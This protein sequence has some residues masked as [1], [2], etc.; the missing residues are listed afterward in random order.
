[1][2]KCEGFKMFRGTM[3]VRSGN[4]TYLITGTWLFNPEYEC[5]Y[6]GGRSFPEDC[7][8]VYDDRTEE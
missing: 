6:C 1:M 3:S 8:S 2:L 5:W 4:K 7:C